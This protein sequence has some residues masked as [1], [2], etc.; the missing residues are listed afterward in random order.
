ME[1]NFNV[2]ALVDEIFEDE[3]IFASCVRN[4]LKNLDLAMESSG[5][6]REKISRLLSIRSHVEN[7]LPANRYNAFD[8]VPVTYERLATGV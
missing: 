3:K 8:T 2:L 1:S 7:Q 4:I 6:D 5:N